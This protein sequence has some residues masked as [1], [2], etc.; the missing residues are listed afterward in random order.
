LLI[1]ASEELTSCLNLAEQKVKTGDERIDAS[2][3]LPLLRLKDALPYL[4]TEDLVYDSPDQQGEY[5]S[6]YGR[7]IEGFYRLESAP[8]VVRRLSD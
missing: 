3:F 8:Q 6:T 5:E 7:L 2:T 4:L 1:D